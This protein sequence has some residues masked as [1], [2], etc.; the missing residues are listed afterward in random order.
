MMRIRLETDAIYLILSKIHDKTYNSIKSKVH[1]FEVSAISDVIERQ[2]VLALLEKF[3]SSNH[4]VLQ[5]VRKRAQDLHDMGFGLAD[6]A[7]LAHAEVTSDT[8]ISCDDKVL[9]KSKINNIL[10]P[11]YDPVEFV[12]KENLK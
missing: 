10:I 11:V 6:A 5:D 9:K 1:T 12:I 2:E 3:D 7:H 8:F 4:Y